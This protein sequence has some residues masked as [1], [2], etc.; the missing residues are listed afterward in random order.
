M[1][2]SSFNRHH[3]LAAVTHQLEQTKDD[4]NLSAL[5]VIDIAEFQKVNQTIGYS[6]G[7]QLLDNLFTRLVSVV[8][9][10]AHCHRVNGDKFALLISPL[11]S[12]QL[13]PLLAKKIIDQITRVF[14]IDNHRVQ[15]KAHIG[16]AVSTDKPSAEQLLL[17]AEA[18]AKAARRKKISYSLSQSSSYS[19]SSALIVLERQISEALNNNDFALFYQPKICLSSQRPSGAEGLIRWNKASD[20]NISSEQLVA[21]ME[22]CGQ[23]PELFRWTIN[24]ALRE[25]SH[26]PETHG[27]LSVAINLSAS[28]LQQD[29]LFEQIESSLNLWGGDPS[30]LCIEV[31]ESAVQEDMSHGLNQLNK[32]KEL[33][34]KIAIDDFGTGYSSLEYFKYIPAN[35]LKIDRSFVANMLDSKVDMEIVKLI[36]EWGRRLELSTVAEGIECPKALEILCELNCGFAQ[37]YHFSKALPE[38]EFI[39]WLAKFDSN[40]Y[41]DQHL[42][43]PEEHLPLR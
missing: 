32:I 22:R 31:T 11:V 2:A 26:W 14:V 10:E 35:E 41:F 40:Q 5:A 18:E 34:V 39:E 33:G 21:T 7:D 36:L 15:L 4:N 43:H 17:E 1:T 37:G 19:Q 24:T 25:S 42:T 20:L 3:F 12:I 13:I 8:K 6:L 9:N 29:S 23:M 38:S 28:C 30:C 16:F 27:P